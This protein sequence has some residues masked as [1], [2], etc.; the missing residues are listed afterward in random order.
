[1]ELVKNYPS[2]GARLLETAKLVSHLA[3]IIESY[4]ENWDG[5]GYPH[6]LKG[7]EIPLESRIISLVDDFVAMTSDRP[8]R[9]TM[10][11]EEAIRLIEQHS[12]KDYD[13]QLV[14]VFLGLLN[15]TISIAKV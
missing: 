14:R 9:P 3:P 10:T 1:M 13:P 12:G 4:Q 7:D 8:Y 5:T 11:E 6:G 15:K 2:A